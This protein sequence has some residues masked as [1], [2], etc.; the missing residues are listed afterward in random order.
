MTPAQC[1][2][3]RAA[4]EMEIRELAGRA[5]VATGTIVRLERGEAL[6]ERTIDAIQAALEAAGVEF[7]DGDQPGVR[8]R[9]SSGGSIPVEQLN[10]ANDD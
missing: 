7:T 5:K 9:K 1:R 6:K 3:A 4:L 8:L 2:M 10:A